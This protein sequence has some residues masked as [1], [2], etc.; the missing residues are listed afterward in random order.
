MTATHHDL[1]A[2]AD[3]R[4]RHDFLPGMCAECRPAPAGLPSRVY[5]SSAGLVFHGSASC[6]ALADGQAKARRFGYE[7]RPASQLPLTEAQSGTGP[8][9]G[10]PARVLPDPTMNPRQA[11]TGNRPHPAG[12]V[13]TPRAGRVEEGRRGAGRSNPGPG[14]GPTPA[15][16]SGAPTPRCSGNAAA[17]IR[18]PG[19]QHSIGGTGRLGAGRLRQPGLQPTG[20]SSTCTGSPLIGPAPS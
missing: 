16:P 3:R 18:R 1:P 7:T 20:G 4:C 19:R 15:Q 2:L 8:V 11:A 10:L 12:Q 6:E 17:P 9:H 13:A 5:V 14:S